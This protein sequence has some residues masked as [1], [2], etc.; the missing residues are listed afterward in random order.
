MK[1]LHFALL[2]LGALFAVMNSGSLVQAAKPLGEMPKVRLCVAL[3]LVL[4]VNGVLMGR[5][6]ADDFS[7]ELGAIEAQSLV[8]VG[9][10]SIVQAYEEL[11]NKYP[12][13][14][15][16]A[17]AMMKIA[18][19]WGLNLAKA[20]IVPDQEKVGEWLLKVRAETE[21]G[22]ELWSAASL[23][24]AGNMRYSDPAA[25]KELLLEV[26]DHTR[27]PVTEVESYYQLQCIA[28]HEK[29]YDEAERIC[30]TLQEWM[31]DENKQ[32]E[33]MLEKGKFF[34]V[35]QGSATSMMI[36][37]SEM[38]APT[39]VRKAK[40]DGLYESYRGRRYM[41]QAHQEAIEHLNRMPVMS[42][43]TFKKIQRLSGQR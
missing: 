40:I 31:V 33:S 3:L 27:D 36:A 17:R 29:D 6:E 4:L 19:L 12:E 2:T 10:D 35:I 22:D 21:P 25:A 5:C 7:S 13:H 1:L 43:E 8:E 34:Q 30:L 16:R 32:P 26:F 9:R 38:L 37:W 42:D 23:R 39:H 11:V 24:I 20:K 15:G 14:P 28:R 41:E 18:N